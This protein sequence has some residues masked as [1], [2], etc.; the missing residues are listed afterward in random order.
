VILSFID[1][2]AEGWASEQAAK[3]KDYQWLTVPIRTDI[4]FYI[5]RTVLAVKKCESGSC[6]ATVGLARGSS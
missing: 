4:K 1:G 5:A 3:V 6:K 2:H